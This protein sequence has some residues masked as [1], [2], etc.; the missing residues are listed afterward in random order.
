MSAQPKLAPTK[1]VTGKVRFSYAHVFEPHAQSDGQEKKYSVQLIIPKT[2]TKTVKAIK[3]A[4]EAAIAEKYPNKRPQ[5]L[6]MPLRDGDIEDK[7]ES[8]LGAYFMNVSSK[9][10]P[11]IVDAALNKIIDQTEFYSGCYGRASINAFTYD[12]SGNKGVSFGLQN[13]QKTQDGEPL[14][15]RSR[16]EDDFAEAFDDDDDPAF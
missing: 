13:L 15:S 7:G 10:A 8:V 11:G 6:R 14:G 16:A 3:A 12:N 5:N 9:N 4:I 2:D 1:V